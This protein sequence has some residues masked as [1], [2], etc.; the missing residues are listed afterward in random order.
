MFAREKFKATIQ[1]ICKKLIEFL[2]VRVTLKIQLR[3]FRTLCMQ[4]GAKK[5]RDRKN[6]V[7]VF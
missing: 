5:M 4:Y 7:K 6:N 3:G 1:G 2:L